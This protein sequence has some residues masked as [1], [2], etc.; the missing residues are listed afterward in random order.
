MKY[1]SRLTKAERVWI[2]KNIKGL[3]FSESYYDYQNECERDV[4][5]NLDNITEQSIGTSYQPPMTD[6]DSVMFDITCEVDGDIMQY[7]QIAVFADPG[8]FDR[9]KKKEVYV[10]IDAYEFYECDIGSKVLNDV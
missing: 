5:Y 8:L 1:S 3:K 9:M 6:D 2:A 7:R 10:T 4:V